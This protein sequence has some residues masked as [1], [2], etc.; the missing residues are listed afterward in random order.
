MYKCITISAQQ[1]LL[2][3]HAN[4][5]VH[6]TGAMDRRKGARSSNKSSGLM[7]PDAESRK[8]ETLL[9]DNVL[10]LLLIIFALVVS[11]RRTVSFLPSHNLQLVLRSPP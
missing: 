11:F 9:A 8:S 6:P 1:P 7:N 2:S 3:N 10:L 4:I 5:L